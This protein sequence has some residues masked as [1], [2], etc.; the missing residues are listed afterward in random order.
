MIYLADACA[1]IVFLGQDEPAHVMPAGA[2]VMLRE[3]VCVLSITF[4]EITRKVAL[5]KLPRIG[6]G[7]L[8]SLL[9]AQQFRPLNLT[10]DDGEAANNLPDH[11]RDPMDRMMIAAALR[12]D[13]TI[14]TSDRIFGAYGVKT[15]W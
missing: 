15:L 8:A 13:M 10:W 6:H 14:I 7:S 5:G 12:S 11:H 3:N 9:R 4:W 2:Q 1:L